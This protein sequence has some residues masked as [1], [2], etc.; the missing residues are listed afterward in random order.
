M[1]SPCLCAAHLGP[2]RKCQEDGL[3]PNEGW[4]F[5]TSDRVS[6]HRLHKGSLPFRPGPT[7]PDHILT[8][9]TLQPLAGLLP[10]QEQVPAVSPEIHSQYRHSQSPSL[11]GNNHHPSVGLVCS[12]SCVSR[13]PLAQ[14]APGVGTTGHYLLSLVLLS[15]TFFFFLAFLCI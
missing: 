7:A 10:V 14:F 3:W 4:C 11:Q 13:A 15:V 1:H 2:F 12:L 6:E 8:P 5:Y 9:G